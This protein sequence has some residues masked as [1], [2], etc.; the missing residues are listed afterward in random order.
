MSTTRPK[1]RRLVRT[2][3]FNV[4]VLA[5]LSAL[6]GALIDEQDQFRPP[7]AIVRRVLTDEKLWLGL[8]AMTGRRALLESKT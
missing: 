6:A 8:L 5:M 2:L 4:G 1:R 7:G 3:T